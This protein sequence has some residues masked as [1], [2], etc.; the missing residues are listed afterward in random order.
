MSANHLVTLDG[1]R[2]T[3]R[4]TIVIRR[5]QHEN[6]KRFDTYCA[7]THALVRTPAGWK[8]GAVKQAADKGPF[9]SLAPSAA[10]SHLDPS[11]RPAAL[12]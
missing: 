5:F 4:S 6:G 2:A 11:R 3:C 7:Y 8:I 1:D 10:A 12:G 9:P